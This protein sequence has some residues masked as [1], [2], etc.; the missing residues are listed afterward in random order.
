MKKH[1]VENLVALSF[2]L[3]TLRCS[4]KSVQAPSC[5]RP[6]ST[7]RTMFLL[8]EYDICLQTR[9]KKFLVVLEI[10]FGGFFKNCITTGSHDA[11]VILAMLP[12][13]VR[14]L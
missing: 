14:Y 2:K 9:H 12:M 5:E 7:Q 1:E 10:G 8:Y 4:N 13:P 11:E 6:K 3:F